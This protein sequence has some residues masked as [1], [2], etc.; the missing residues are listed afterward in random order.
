[1]AY[2]QVIL[3]R[4]DLKLP[5]GKLAVQASHASVDSVLKSLSRDKEK[6]R[7]WRDE[8][9][10]KIVLRVAD[11]AE[12]LYFFNTFKEKGIVS[13]L[14]TDAGK[15]VVMPGTKTCISAG[16]DKEDILDEITSQLKMI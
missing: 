9:M 3:V 14:I 12:L 5:K 11:E 7:R 10:K 6:V 16:P 8:G 13:A 4:S 15:T 1:M 2:K